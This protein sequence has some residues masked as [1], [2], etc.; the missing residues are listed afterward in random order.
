MPPHVIPEIAAHVDQFVGD[1]E[2]D[3]VFTSPEGASLRR[4]NFNRP[5]WRPACAEVAL[6]SLRFHDLRHT[7]NTLAAT[8]G[9]KHKG[10]HGTDGTRKTGSSDFSGV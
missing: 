2:D 10:A 5:K 8:T 9:C 3:V 1:S 4:S 6:D 7:G